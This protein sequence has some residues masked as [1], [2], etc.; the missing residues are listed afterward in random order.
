M[1]ER[2]IF[3]NIINNDVEIKYLK[4]GWIK[5]PKLLSKK[6][7]NNLKKKISNFLK[8]N[9]KNY[10]KRN[11]NFILNKKKEKVIHSFHKLADSKVIKKFATKKNFF[12]IAEK[13]IGEESKFRKCELFAK[14]SKIG[15][16]SPPHQDNFY[17]CLKNGKS[18]TFWIALEKSDKKN[19][20]MYYF[21]GSHKI[22]L[23]NH[24]ASNIKGSSQT[25]K[26]VKIYSKYNKITPSLNAGDALVHDSHII[27]GSTK[28]NSKKNRMGLT[29]QFQ[30]KKCKIDNKRQ[31]I[32]LKSL[33][34]QIKK[35]SDA[36]I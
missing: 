24:V 15:I 29:I 33:N 8:K 7:V 25:V 35:R 14:P 2:K 18:L 30:S 12:N 19:G 28:N 9:N 1:N 34:Q 21:N 11:V 3:S 31:K 23:V 17:W 16:K 36:R 32:Y 10:D 20:A 26:D 27:H 22:G 5:I 6:Q 4:N 13:L